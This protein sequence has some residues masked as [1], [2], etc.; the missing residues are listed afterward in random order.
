LSLIEAAEK[1]STA[2]NGEM[3]AME[4]MGAMVRMAIMGRIGPLNLIGTSI[5]ILDNVVK[6]PKIAIVIPRSLRRGISNIRYLVSERKPGNFLSNPHL[7]KGGFVRI[8][9]VLSNPPCPPLRK[10]GF[11][12]GAIYTFLFTKRSLAALGMTIRIFYEGIIL[13]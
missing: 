7:A 13:I 4:I 6:K 5:V 9:L 2:G 10:G 8:A 12:S 11:R 1:K 3:E